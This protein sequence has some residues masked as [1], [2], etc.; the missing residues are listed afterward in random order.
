MLDVQIPKTHTCFLQGFQL[1][2]IFWAQREGLPNQ[3]WWTKSVFRPLRSS[4]LGSRRFCLLQIRMVRHVSLQNGSFIQGEKTSMSKWFFEDCFSC[5]SFSFFHVFFD[6]HVGPI[7][8]FKFHGVVG[9]Y[10]W[11]LWKFVAVDFS[12]HLKKAIPAVFC[13]RGP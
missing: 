10:R 3:F 1:T 12:F 11:R 8:Y 5:F 4:F 7:F 13:R 6:S 2:P 9:N